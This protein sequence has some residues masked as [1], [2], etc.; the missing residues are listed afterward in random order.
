[1]S[2]A[3]PDPQ[4]VAIQIIADALHEVMARVAYVQKDS[5]NSFHGYKYVSEAKL[6]DALRP[7]LVDVG[8]IFIPTFE[9]GKTDLSTGNTDIVMS[10][11]LMHK[12]GAVWP[13]KIRV[14]G[15]G[16]DKN[17]TGIGDKGVY[18]AMTGANK[19]FFFKL[20]QIATGD[21]PEME[22]TPWKA[23]DKPSDSDGLVETY[24][25]AASVMIN[26]FNTSTDLK[27]WWDGSL[28]E[29]E[30]L[31]LVNGNPAY[32]KLVETVTKRV[33]ELKGIK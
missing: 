32:A 22:G 30:T 23:S 28:G 17:K 16:N 24:L 21:D 2:N 12:S 6:L 18:K 11:T 10:Y 14:A 29:R 3:K 27:A 13:E 33:V 15:C 9:E 31:G 1:M 5:T 4:F 26:S 20:F 25:Q 19:Y 8:L 7:V